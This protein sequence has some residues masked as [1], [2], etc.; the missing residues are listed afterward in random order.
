VI[1]LIS[2]KT[3]IMGNLGLLTGMGKKK[4]KNFGKF[5][6]GKGIPALVFREDPANKESLCRKTVWLIYF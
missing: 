5:P 6:P 3:Q 1:S 4:K 2:Y